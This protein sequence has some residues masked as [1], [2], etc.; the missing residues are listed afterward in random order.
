MKQDRAIKPCEERGNTT[1]GAGTGRL[2][3][4]DRR[5][6]LLSTASSQFAMTGLHGTTPRRLACAGGV[7]EAVLYQHFGSK[8]QLFRKAVEVNSEMRLRLLDGH[9]SSIAA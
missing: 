4:P 8:T 3:G 2:A 7:S 6:Q 5:V 9:L 1:A